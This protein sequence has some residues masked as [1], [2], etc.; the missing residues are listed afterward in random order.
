MICSGQ[1]LKECMMS[2]EN[3]DYIEA[4]HSK[5]YR[6]TPQRLIVLD[7]VCDLEHHATFADIHAKVV[8]MDS[9]ID[10]STIYRALA[11]LLEVG[12]IVESEIGELGKVYR[13]AG[14][15]D[16]HHLICR[17][18]GAVLTIHEDVMQPM[19]DY[20]RDHYGFEVQSEHLVF[21]GMCFKCKEH[22]L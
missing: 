16:H 4:L 21:K 7:A 14:E 22:A 5:G 19:I 20:F 18:C 1:L 3:I 6:V 11:V 12:L 9:T 17:S 13:V 15:S 10:R 8:E 2:H